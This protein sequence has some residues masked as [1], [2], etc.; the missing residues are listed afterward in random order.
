MRKPMASAAVIGGGPAGSMAARLLAGRFDVTVLESR[1]TSGDP[2]QCT[3]LITEESVRMSGIRPDILNTVYGAKVH[4]PGGGTIS[5]RSNKPKGVLVDRHDFDMR[6]AGAAMDAGAEYRYSERFGRAVF[7]PDKVSVISSGGESDAD[8]LIGA[9]GH[10]SSV[11]RDAGYAPPRFVRGIQVDIKH[12]MEDQEIMELRVGSAAPG[13][14]SWEIPLGDHTRVGLCTRWSA[15]P[16]W[17]HLGR[18]LTKAGLDGKEVVSKVSGKIPV[19]GVDRTFGD[20]MMLIGDAAGQVKPVSGG[21]IYPMLKAAPH[22]ASAAFRALDEG[23]FSSKRLSGYEKGWKGEVGGELKRGCTMVK[24]YRKMSDEDLDRVF[25]SADTP[26]MRSILNDID[27][28]APSKV[29][30]RML[31]HP[32]L[33]LRLVPAVMRAVI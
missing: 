18:L 29:V 14:F 17:G 9:D 15:G 25:I 6:M 4:F 26:E 1:A 12:R 7:L 11:L 21:G 16:P 8:L 3:G 10:T 23:D 27:L 32:V 19:G 33:A 20:R 13:S 31:R 28:D 22:L 2:V 30:L 5:V 24:M